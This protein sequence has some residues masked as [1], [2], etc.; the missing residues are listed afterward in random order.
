MFLGADGDL[1]F[2]SE[3]EYHP[4]D[5]EACKEVTKKFQDFHER[6]VKALPGK[7]I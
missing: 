1:N 2:D 3:D 4:D 7:T 6:S 5:S